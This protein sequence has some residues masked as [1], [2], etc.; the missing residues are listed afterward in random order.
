MRPIC[1]GCEK[2]PEAFMFGWKCEPCSLLFLDGRVMEKEQCRIHSFA[3]EH[4]VETGIPEVIGFDFEE[5]RRMWK[6]RSFQ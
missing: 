2:E 4:T 3:P 1:P 5:C 6:L